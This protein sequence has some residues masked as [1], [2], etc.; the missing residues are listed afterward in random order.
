MNDH[1]N[2]IIA[3]ALDEKRANL[4]EPEAKR[5][6]KEYGISTPLFRVVT[7]VKDAVKSARSIGFPVVLKAVSPDIIH[8]TEAGCVMLGLRDPT[9]VRRAFSE[10][11]SNAQRRVQKAR[12]NGVLVEKMLPKGVEVIVG[13]FKDPQF[14]QTLMFGL[15]GIFVELF[16][17]V[18]FRVAPL[19]ERDVRTMIKEIKGYEILKGHRGQPPA[20]EES[21][22]RII[23]SLSKLLTDHSEISETDLNPTI[24]YDR[25]AMIADARMTLET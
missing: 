20:D 24:V 18:S 1:V 9:E 7:N 13:G 16:E 25:G 11:L 4:L 6:C 21:L 23:M 19:R 5:I 8:K 22:V 2:E 10:I 12:V 17:D 15:G 14:G 3:N